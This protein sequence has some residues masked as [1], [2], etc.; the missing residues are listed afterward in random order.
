VKGNEKKNKEKLK[1]MTIKSL[2]LTGA[3]AVGSLS[4]ASAKSYDIVLSSPTKVANV[5]LKAGEYRVKVEG[6]NAVFTDV[7]SGKSVTAAAKIE[8]GDKKFDETAVSTEKKADM[9]QMQS[10]ELGGSH[11][12]IEFSES[13]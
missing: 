12:K 13:E 7:E 8:T 11:T 6:N 10:I 3:L 1:A 5:Q 2:I 9:D 4:I